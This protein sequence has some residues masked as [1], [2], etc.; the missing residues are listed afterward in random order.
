MATVR[1]SMAL[2]GT[3]A[4]I[5]GAALL[6]AIPIIGQIITGL[7][8]AYEA[9]TF[10]REAMKTDEQ[11]AY[12]E[13]ASKTEETLKELIPT[14]KNLEA[15][16]KGQEST[17][18]S[19]T[20]KW[21][22]YNNVLRQVKSAIAEQG[23]AATTEEAYQATAKALQEQID[24]ISQLK[25]S[26]EASLGSTNIQTLANDKYKGSIQLA[27]QAVL[28]HMGV[29]ANRATSILAVSAAL[30]EGQKIFG[31]YYN[32]LTKASEADKFVNSLT[33]I[34]TALKGA[35]EDSPEVVKIIGEEMDETTA[36][37]AGALQEYKAMI[38][39]SLI[40]I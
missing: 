25:E 32:S 18:T 9:F 19:T 11:K 30:E 36:K 13:I 10:L 26:L 7:M 39:L 29:E 14:I 35:G 6:N 17:I 1:A 22:V 28:K 38:Q 4:K 2:T 16:F 40:H 24:K 23:D 37:F 15:A 5:F 12:E 34:T 33:Q 27:I 20:Q 21:E 8:L 31:D 3:A